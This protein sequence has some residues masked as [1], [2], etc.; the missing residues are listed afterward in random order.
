MHALGFLSNLTL[1]LLWRP[2]LAFALLAFAL[3]AFAVWGVYQRCRA[4]EPV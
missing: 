2:L 1:A 4:K 3:M